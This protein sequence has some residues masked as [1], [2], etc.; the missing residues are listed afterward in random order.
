MTEKLTP[1]EILARH[2]DD[3]IIIA[4]ELLSEGLSKNLEVY[5]H[6]MWQIKSI[7]ASIECQGMDDFSVYWVL[8]GG[9]DN[10]PIRLVNGSDEESSCAE[11]DCPRFNTCELTKGIL[12]KYM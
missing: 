8:G 5:D 2:K 11:V 9:F 12:D 4:Q 1:K 6:L 3:F 7:E 10:C